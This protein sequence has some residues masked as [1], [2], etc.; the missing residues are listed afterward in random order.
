MPSFKEIL[1]SKLAEAEARH[2]QR[3]ETLERFQVPQVMNYLVEHLN[4]GEEDEFS[5]AIA[6]IWGSEIRPRNFGTRSFFYPDAAA[7]V[8]LY[9]EQ[10]RGVYEDKFGSN[11]GY[12]PG[13]RT[14]L[15]LFTRHSNPDKLFLEVKRRKI[16][17]GSNGLVLRGGE[18][19]SF[20]LDQ[21]ET[22]EDLLSEI[23]DLVVDPKKKPVDKYPVTFAN[24]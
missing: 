1:S 4:R 23:I 13:E 3:N 17:T 20:E 21:P 5:L 19:V 9:G 14:I 2:I 11:W 22:P 8:Y 6:G 24:F 10:S 7:S 18:S 15:E 16:D 12:P